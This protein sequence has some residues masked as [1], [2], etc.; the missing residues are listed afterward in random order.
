MRKTGSIW[1]TQEQAQVTM[2]KKLGRAEA[3]TWG[4]N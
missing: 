3:E 4:I 1:E 2:K